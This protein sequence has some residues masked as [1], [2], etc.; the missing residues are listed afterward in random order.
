[1][2][3]TQRALFWKLHARHGAA[4]TRLIEYANRTDKRGIAAHTRAAEDMAAAAFQIV[5]LLHQVEKAAKK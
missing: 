4:H 5:R 3:K 1:M 2:T